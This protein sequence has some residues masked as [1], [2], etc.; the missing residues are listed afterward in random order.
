MRRSVPRLKRGGKFGFTV[1]AGPEQNPD[2]KIVNDAIEAYANLNVGLPG[3]PPKYLY[4]ERKECWQVLK[5]AGFDDTSM[6]YDTRT[7]NGICRMRVT[8]LKRNGT[9]AVEPRAS[10]R[11]NSRKRWE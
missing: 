3:G 1:W 4:G 9:P 6:S 8:I 5:R 11:G 2:A 10:W 7:L